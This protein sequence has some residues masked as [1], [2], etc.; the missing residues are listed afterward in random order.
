MIKNINSNFFKNSKLKLCTI[1]TVGVILSA[2]LTGCAFTNNMQNQDNNYNI[3]ENAT[4]LLESKEQAIIN[5]EYEGLENIAE[6]DV[7]TFSNPET[8]E[9]LGIA[10]TDREKKELTLPPGRY[11]VTSNYLEEEYFEIENSKEE[12]VV[13]AVYNSN[14]FK[15]TEKTN[16]KSQIK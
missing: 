8:A 5:L 3:T 4:D 12:W 11:M 14:T 16:E 9:I 10:A 7:I 15:I 2:S 13:E 6:R 1:G